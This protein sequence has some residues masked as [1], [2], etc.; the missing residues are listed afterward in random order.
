MRRRFVWGVPALLYALFCFWY[1]DCGGPLRSDEIAGYLVAFER[2]GF[3][4]EQQ[5]DVRSFMEEHEPT[6]S[7]VTLPRRETAAPHHEL[8]TLLSAV[9]AL[10]P[11]YPRIGCIVVGG[12]R[13]TLEQD[14][15]RL[16][17]APSAFIT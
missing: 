16:T 10:R 6:L 5:A 12:S 3:T 4:A 1:T 9:R 17:Q 8:E 15:C 11:L 2:Q 14:Y 7:T 13:R